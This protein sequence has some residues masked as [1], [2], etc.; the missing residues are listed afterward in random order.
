MLCQLY[1][2]KLYWNRFSEIKRKINENYT[3]H[4]MTNINVKLLVISLMYIDIPQDA[5]INDKK[6]P[7]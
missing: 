1:V 6:R 2:Q 7:M 4:K 3:G 5:K